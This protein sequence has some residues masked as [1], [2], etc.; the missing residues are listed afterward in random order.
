MC[1]IERRHIKETIHWCV[2]MCNV[3]DRFL[4]E[5]NESNVSDGTC[6][7]DRSEYALS[8]DG[9]IHSS[10]CLNNIQ[11]KKTNSMRQMGL[12]R[13]I[14]SE[15]K[16]FIG[17]HWSQHSYIYAFTCTHFPTKVLKIGTDST[18]KAQTFFP[19]K[20]PSLHSGILHDRQALGDFPSGLKHRK[21]VLPEYKTIIW[22][23]SFSAAQQ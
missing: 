7:Q 5:E 6:V 13:C 22:F 9:R 18:S 2:C 1:M 20:S 17:I 15:E 11:E 14:S 10:Q 23:V 21:Y 19:F 4:G 12:V 3:H 8:S 16:G